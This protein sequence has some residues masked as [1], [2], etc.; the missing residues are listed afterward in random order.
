MA[1]LHAWIHYSYRT[2]GILTDSYISKLF[3]RLRNLF[4][5][6][7]SYRNHYIRESR[8]KNPLS[9]L[10]AVLGLPAIIILAG[11]PAAG[12][13]REK[14][15]VAT[16]AGGCFWCM[17]PPFDMIDGVISTTPGYT[18]G[19][20]DNP[21]YRQVSTGRTGHT[22]AIQIVYDPNKVTYQQLLEIYWVNVD[23]L[24]KNAQFCDR[25]SQYRSGIF[26]Q[27][28]DQEKLATASGKAIQSIFDMPVVTEI[29]KF[30]KFY[31]AEERH[32]NYYLKNPVRYNYF[33]W[34]CGRDQ[35]LEELWGT[36]EK[37]SEGF[38]NAVIVSVRR[39][40]Y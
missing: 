16:F 39:L 32:Q 20:I 18:A 24:T 35:R 6:R 36:A 11:I 40:L 37:K 21:T 33:R 34:G 3:P 23:P 14:T 29:T 27:D 1:G 26:Y 2:L 12:A 9:R 13:D 38:L 30:S 28:A 17:E 10:V 22:E 8:M 15:A 7:G 5:V 19:L 4:P 25:G 31:P